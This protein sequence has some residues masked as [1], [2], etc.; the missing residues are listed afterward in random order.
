MTRYYAIDDIE[1]TKGDDWKP[2]Y[3]WENAL[4]EPVNIAGFSFSLSIKQF[5]TDAN[6]LHTISGTISDAPN[7]QFYFLLPSS[8]TQTLALGTYYYDVQVIDAASLKL[9]RV[10]GQLTVSWEGVISS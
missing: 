6:P 3:K 4:G 8:I 5:E 10:K 7:G 2:S 9:T 1:I